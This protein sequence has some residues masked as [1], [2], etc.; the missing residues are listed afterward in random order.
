[1]KLLP[2]AYDPNEPDLRRKVDEWGGLQAGDVVKV[3]GQ[4]GATF[5]FRSATVD[6]ETV[7][8]V[9]LYGGRPHHEKLRSFKWDELKIPTERQLAKQRRIRG[10]A[11]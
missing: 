3:T 1:M 4:P 7:L 5:K 2:N 9:N 8:W 10:E 11:T 6:G